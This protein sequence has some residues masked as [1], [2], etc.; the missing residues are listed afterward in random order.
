MK[1]A[2]VPAQVTTIEDTII[3]NLTP[4]QI[5]L[6]LIPLFLSIAI[7]V[8]VPESK[9]ISLSKAMVILGVSL[10]FLI[11]AIRFQGKLVLSWLNILSRYSFRPR[12]YLFNKQD[13][14][15]KDLIVEKKVWKVPTLSFALRR[16]KKKAEVQK[17]DIASLFKESSKSFVFNLSTSG[18]VQLKRYE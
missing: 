3:G 12:L 15:L 10:V 1:T 5:V 7:Y 18:K 13:I 9:Q 11:L 2:T 8:F 6:F 17:T 4:T 14:Y 16:A